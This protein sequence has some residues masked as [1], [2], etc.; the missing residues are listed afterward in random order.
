MLKDAIK[1]NLVQTLEGTQPLSTVPLCQHCPW[2]Q[3]CYRDK[4]ALRLADCVVTEAGFGFDLGGKDFHVRAEWRSL[5]LHCHG[6][7]EALKMHGG[8]DK[9]SLNIP[10]VAAV[11][12]GATW[13][14]VL[15]RPRNLR[16]DRRLHQPLHAGY[17]DEVDA[18]RERCLALG[19]PAG[20]RYVWRDRRGWRCCRRGPRI[21]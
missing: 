19:V 17:D 9:K 4:M 11:R 18:V 20:W 16:A 3:H 2:N 5:L 6:F 10:D 13:R 8:I 7:D 14:D 1:P 12:R 21:G 15:N